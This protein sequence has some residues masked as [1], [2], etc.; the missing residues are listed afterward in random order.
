[1]SP[2]WIWG[3]CGWSVALAAP[4][5]HQEAPGA[6]VAVRSAA[7]AEPGEERSG[8][9][10]TVFD[11]RRTAYGRAA[12]NLSPARWAELRAGKERFARDWPQ[13]GPWS[14]AS[15][16]ADCHFFDGRGPG[17]GALAHGPVQLLRLGDASGGG[18]PR[19]GRQLRRQGH[20][21]PTPGSFVVEWEEVAGHYPSGE[22]FVLR[23]PVVRLT[24]L[25]HGPLH[26]STRTSLRMPPAMVGLGLLEAVPE[27][28]L[29]AAADPSDRDG[30]GISG[31]AQRGLDPVS[32][33]AALGRFGWKAGQPSLL[34]QAATAL[35][36]D[37]GVVSPFA[38]AAGGDAEITGEE[39]A[40][41]V[42]YL[43]GLGVPGRR[44]WDTPL[45]RRGQALFTEIGCAG[46]HRP[47]LT[48]GVLPGWPELS[49]QT[50]RPYTDLLLH[51]LGDELADA[52]GEGEASGREWR[53]APLWGLGLLPEVSGDAGL[54]HDGR[55]RS[56]EEA[57]LWHGGEAERARTRWKGLPGVEREA[58]VAFLGSL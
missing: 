38:A 46:C 40:T 26:Q 27:E 21:V 39:V 52:V 23:R 41:L 47:R 20:G 1:V 37:L 25:A 10:T 54:L 18:D 42:R 8:G 33:R 29:L 7:V 22:R 35:A 32:H 12:A 4:A 5:L 13:R 51:D 55:A 15:S 17:P 16:C 49:A 31:R 45:V 57:I 56:A 44:D 28:A 14:D 2:R 36:E 48:T 58:L 9:D 24:A 43:R 53:T 6:A 19:Y 11:G 3:L 30:D 50:I 34:G